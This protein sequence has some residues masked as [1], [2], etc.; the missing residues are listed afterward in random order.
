MK[1]IYISAIV[2][3]FL[4]STLFPLLSL[5]NVELVSAQ[6]PSKIIQS[7]DTNEEFFRVLREDTGEIEIIA[8]TDYI[9]GVV[10]AEM[11]AEYETEALKAQAVAAYTFACHRKAARE[12]KDYDVTD[13]V[14]DQA[15]ISPDEQREKWGDGYEKYSQKIRQAVESVKGQVLTFEGKTILAAYHSISG[16]KTE[17]AANV[18]GDGY[19]YLQSVESVGDV[20]SPNY[21]NTFVF[22]EDELKK[23][24]KDKGVEFSGSADGWFKDK[25]TSDS[26][27]VLSIKVCKTEF[28]GKEIRKILGLKSANFDVSFSDGKFTFTVRGY[29]H[30]MGM[31]QYGAQF[32]ALQGS[33]YAE[34]LNWYYPTATLVTT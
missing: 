14:S 5:G 23:A 2:I 19:P 6:T 28:T 18:W 30:G 4:C 17:A 27:T 34:I 33:S 7:T 15:Y 20:L 31:S 8:V 16:G 9:C 1:G 10:A 3:L 25:K 13:T 22:T 11:P 29:G 21:L 32:M 26:G 12:D 24:F